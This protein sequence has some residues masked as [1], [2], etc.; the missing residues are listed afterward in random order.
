[1]AIHPARPRITFGVT[2]AIL[3]ALAIVAA[4]LVSASRYWIDKVPLT[5]ADTVAMPLENA[6]QAL[7]RGEAILLAHYGRAVLAEE[8][9]LVARLDAGIWMVSG[10]LPPNVAGGVGTVELSAV[11]GHAIQT[12]H[13][14]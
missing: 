9:P 2:L 11:D 8:R 6:G 3:A 14:Q 10:T 13:T 12:Y 4:L 7:H 5:A 1:M